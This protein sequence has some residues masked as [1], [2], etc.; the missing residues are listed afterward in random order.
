MRK[1]GRKRKAKRWQKD[2]LLQPDVPGMTCTEPV[3]INNDLSD[4][5]LY[6]M[7]NWHA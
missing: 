5:F 7:S 2:Y 6:L 1:C 4:I 3:V